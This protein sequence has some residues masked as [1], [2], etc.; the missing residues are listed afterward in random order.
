[1]HEPSADKVPAQNLI[2]ERKRKVTMPLMT[3]DLE[4]DVGPKRIKC[5]EDPLSKPFSKWYQGNERYKW[6]LP[7][8]SGMKHLLI[9]DSMLK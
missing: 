1:M 4:M 7:C 5:L 6:G 8:L 9:G 3:I 2:P